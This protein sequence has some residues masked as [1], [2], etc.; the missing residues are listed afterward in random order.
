LSLSGHQKD[1]EL[2]ENNY[3]LTVLAHENKLLKFLDKFEEINIKDD[4]SKEL[5]KTIEMLEG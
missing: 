3:K 1:K 4:K 2:I 5:L